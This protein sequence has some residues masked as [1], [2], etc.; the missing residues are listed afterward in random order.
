MPTAQLARECHPDANPGDPRPRSGSRRSRVAYETLRDPERRRRYDMFGD[1][2]ARRRRG[3]PAAARRS[4]SATCSTR[5]SGGDAFGGGGRGGPPR[6][7]DAETVVRARP[8]EAAFGVTATRRAALPVACDALRRLRLRARHAPRRAA[9]TCGG[10]RRGP[11]GPPLDPRPDRHRRRRASRASGTGQ[12]IP[13]PCTRVP[14]RRPRAHAARTIEVE[15]PA[16]IDDGQRL[17]LAG[18]RSRRAARRRA[19][20]LYVTVRVAPDPSSNGTATT[21]C[22]GARSRD[23]GRA[24]HRARRSTRSTARGAITVPPGTQPGPRVPAQGPRRAGAAAVAVAATS[25]RDRR[26]GPA[27]AVRRGGASCCAQFAELRGEEVDAAREGLLLA[28][29]R[30]AFGE[31]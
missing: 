13:N 27:R 5:S 8:R 19:G 31:R 20:D 16:G 17:R 14:R 15:V 23:P 7:P 24:R 30:S 22:T 25:R 10:A 28:D 21:S 29:L 9:T 11:P 3:R 12:S 4:A 1:D 2:G 18:P 26:R 6:G